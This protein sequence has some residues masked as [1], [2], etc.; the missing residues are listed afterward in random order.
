MTIAA[1]ANAPI[2]MLLALLCSSVVLVPALAR[3]A[4]EWAGR[5]LLDAGSAASAQIAVADFNGFS[6]ATWP[7]SL[8]RDPSQCRLEEDIPG[9]FVRPAMF[10]AAR[11]RASNTAQRKL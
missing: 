6:D 3:Q 8:C 1:Q 9:V 2:N 7:S 10:P 11:M 4:P 5:T